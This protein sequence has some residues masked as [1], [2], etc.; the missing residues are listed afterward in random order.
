MNRTATTWVFAE[1]ERYFTK[2][3]LLRSGISGHLFLY[4]NRERSSTSL[5]PSIYLE[6]ALRKYTVT[7]AVSRVSRFPTLHQLFSRTSGNPGLEP[8]WALKGEVTVSRS[9]FNMINL[10]AAGYMSRVR[11]MIDRSGKLSIYHNVFRAYLRGVEI[12]GELRLSRFN[13]FSGLNL[14]D[15]EDSYGEKLEYRPPWKIDSGFNYRINP[16]IRV[17][18]TSRAVGRRW[19]EADNYIEGYHVE[20]AGIVI[21]EN[22]MISGSVSLKNVFDVNCEEEFGYPMPGRTVWVGV[23]WRW[24]GK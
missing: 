5:D 16:D 3:L 22:R 4:D 13:M 6:W 12:N 2:N 24:M 20:D 21:G 15:A 19:T 23:D 8:E 10:S 18:L 11:D 14:L 17:H 9:F 7:G 1:Y